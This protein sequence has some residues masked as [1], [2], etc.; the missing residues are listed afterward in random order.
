MLLFGDDGELYEVPEED[1]E[2]DGD[3]FWLL[4]ADDEDSEDYY[5]FVDV[6]VEEDDEEA[7]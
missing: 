3:G 5:D 7:E 4:A 6:E 2:V 1:V